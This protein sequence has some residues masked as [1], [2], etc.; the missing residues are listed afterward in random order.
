M[1]TK[2]LITTDC[3]L[4][5]WDGIA[6]FLYEIIPRIKDDFDITVV[7]PDFKGEKIEF[8]GVKIFYIKSRFRVADIDVSFP[9]KKMLKNL[10]KQNDVIFSQTIGPIGSLSVKIAKKNKKK[11]V[12]FVHSI[13]W[14]LFSKSIGGFFK[15]FIYNYSKKKSKETL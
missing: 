13:E 8:S 11:I 4:P 5:R 3:F 7:A 9:S 14:E 1:K 2:L 15:K 12:T 6:R 10:V